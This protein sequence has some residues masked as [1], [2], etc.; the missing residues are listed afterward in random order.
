MPV[1]KSVRQA[2]AVEAE[3]ID[4][5]HPAGFSKI[6]CMACKIGIAEE[7]I[8]SDGKSEYHCPRC[9]RTFRVQKL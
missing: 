2:K 8:G 6:R 5:T 3:V 4:S 9:H 7:R 1:I